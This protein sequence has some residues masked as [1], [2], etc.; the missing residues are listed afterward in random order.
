[1]LTW[2]KI[3]HNR[4]TEAQKRRVLPLHR[5]LSLRTTLLRSGC[6][7]IDQRRVDVSASSSNL[8]CNAF[9]LLSVCRS[10]SSVVF[11]LGTDVLFCD[12]AAAVDLPRLY[13]T[14]TTVQLYGSAVDPLS[15]SLIVAR[16]SLRRCSSENHGVRNIL[17]ALY[18]NVIK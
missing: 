10:V 7:K 18:V 6:A 12:S 17:C 13:T 3:I 1:M 9:V 8:P 4:V 16:R 2:Q 5:Q 15:S 11:C 14:C